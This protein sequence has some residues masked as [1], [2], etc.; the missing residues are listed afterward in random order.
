MPTRHVRVRVAQA[1]QWLRRA[2]RGIGLDENAVFITRAIEYRRKRRKPTGADI[3][4][5]GL[6]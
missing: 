4:H 6:L 2:I 5:G 3:A 1:G